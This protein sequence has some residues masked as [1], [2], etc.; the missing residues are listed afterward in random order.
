MHID[1]EQ[2]F[3]PRVLIK[4]GKCIEYLTPAIKN[5]KVLGSATSF[6]IDHLDSV[7]DGGNSNDW[8]SPKKALCFGKA[9]STLAIF[10]WFG[11][12]FSMS[13]TVTCI[14][15]VTLKDVGIGLAI[16]G[17]LFAVCASVQCLLLYQQILAPA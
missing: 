17:L 5:P 15:G 7:I 9:S 8:F 3:S 1:K 10:T 2:M 11:V 4:D 6:V 14:V 12:A 13:I 16:G